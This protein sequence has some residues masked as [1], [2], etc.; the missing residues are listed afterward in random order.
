MENFLKLNRPIEIITFICI[1]W[2]CGSAQ[3]AKIKISCNLMIIYNF[4]ILRP[5]TLKQLRRFHPAACDIVCQGVNLIWGNF[6]DSRSFSEFIQEDFSWFRGCS[7]L[8]SWDLEGGNRQDLKPLPNTLVDKEIKGE[9]RG[10]MRFR[11]L[12]QGS[13]EWPYLRSGLGKGCGHRLTISFCHILS[14]RWYIFIKRN[15]PLIPALFTTW[16]VFH[17]FLGTQ[18]VPILLLIV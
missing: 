3:I 1:F 15:S 6:L 8:L 2:C 7:E 5:F 4:T 10:F 13:F 11:W 12:G 17:A 14:T 9:R 18:M 16:E